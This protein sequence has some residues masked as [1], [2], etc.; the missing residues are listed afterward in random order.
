LALHIFV[1]LFKKKKEFKTLKFCI[2]IIYL[3]LEIVKQDKCP[4]YSWSIILLLPAI[5]CAKQNDMSTLAFKTLIIPITTKVGSLNPT[6]DEVYSIQHHVIKFVSD[7]G[8]VSVFY[9]YSGFLH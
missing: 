7:L 5:Y 4:K 6:Q 1:I 8:Q 2:F 9:L 3:T